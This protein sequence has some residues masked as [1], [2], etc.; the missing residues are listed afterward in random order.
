[1]LDK[2]QYSSWASRML[3]YIRG[4]ENGKLLVDLVLNRTFKY[5]TVTVPGNLTTPATVRDRSYDELIDAKKIREGC[6]IKATIVLQGLPQDIYNLPEWSKFVT[7][8]KLVKDLHNTNFDHLYGYLRQ[9]EAHVNKVRLTRQRFYDPIA[10]KVRQRLFAATIV[11]RKATWQDNVPNQ[12][13]LGIQHGLKK[14]VV[15][16]VN[17]SSYD[18]KVL[19]EVPIHDNHLDNYVIDQ[20]VQEMQY[21]EQPV[22]NNETNIDITKRKTFKIKEKE[23][24]LENDYL[25]EL[26][27]SQ[28][29]VHTAVN[30]LSE[31]IDYQ[32]M[33]KRFIDEYSECVELK[34]ELLKRMTW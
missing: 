28:D 13:D 24:L 6:D 1:M 18:L 30:S 25:L 12:K 33:E 17:L 19:S 22:F 4:K 26:L 31:I 23:L 27:I 32:S 8:V 9:H 34:A 29:L 2:T 3:L 11:K 14:S 5:G 15:L 10:L 7:D 16:M 20:N 21:S